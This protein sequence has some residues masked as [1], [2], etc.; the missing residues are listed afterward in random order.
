MST[1]SVV[2]H[3]NHLMLK[4]SKGSGSAIQWHRVVLVRC[5]V[6]YVSVHWWNVFTF[7][8]QVLK[9]FWRHYCNVPEGTG[10]ISLQCRQTS[11]FV[12]LTCSRCTAGHK[13]MCKEKYVT[14]LRP[15]LSRQFR[16]AIM[17]SSSC[18]FHDALQVYL[19]HMGSDLYPDLGTV[20]FYI[21]PTSQAM[22]IFVGNS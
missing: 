8:V 20:Q 15:S 3:W 13:L 11:Y 16:A 4:F 5:T 19:W 14:R 7:S 6:R 10:E 17:G 1:T 18:L 12:C 2:R 9:T 22:P 21:L